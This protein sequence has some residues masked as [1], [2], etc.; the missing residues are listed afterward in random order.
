M[1]LSASDKLGPY[2]IVGLIGKGGMGEVYRARDPKLK[3][4]VAIKVL[5]EVF[6]RDHERM[7]RFQRE[8][9]EMCCLDRSWVVGHTSI[10]FFDRP[11]LPLGKSNNGMV[12][13][14][15]TARG[16]TTGKRVR[17][18]PGYTARRPIG[19][20]TGGSAGNETQGRLLPLRSG[21]TKGGKTS[22]GD[23][24]CTYTRLA[25]ISVRRVFTW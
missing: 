18:V 21:K 1:S 3:R 9:L 10:N 7:A 25:L 5:P 23:I 8:A 19:R 6:A 12:R 15:D 4:D 16:L 22:Q 20:A 24:P 11:A 13:R 17:L 14:R 2:E